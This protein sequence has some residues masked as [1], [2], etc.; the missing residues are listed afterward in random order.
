MQGDNNYLQ[1]LIKVVRAK[2]AQC[3][4]SALNDREGK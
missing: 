2:N 3:V 4:S 1:I